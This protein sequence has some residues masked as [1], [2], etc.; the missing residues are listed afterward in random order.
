MK[1]LIAYDGSIWSDAA[2]ED[3][4][5][6]GLPARGEVLVVSVGDRIASGSWTSDLT[7]H[8]RLADQASE[9]IQAEFPNW[10]IVS[11]ALWGSPAKIVLDT[12]RW[13]HPDLLVVG[14]HGRSRAG[15]FLLGSVSTELIHKASCS[16]RVA[17]HPARLPSARAPR[18]IIGNDGSPEAE[19]VIRAVRSRSWPEKTEARIV[20]VVET[21]VP[22]VA[23]MEANTFAHE[24]AFEVIREVDE[25]QRNRLRESAERAASLLRA[26]GLTVS[27][28]V[29]DGA[30]RELL[31]SEAQ[32]LKAD[33]IFVGARGLGRMHRLL[34]G[35]VSSYIVTHARCSVEVVRQSVERERNAN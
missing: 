12:S 30:P 26:S 14:S 25:R 15:R 11:E 17:R 5:M 27:P 24:P 35:S 18:I 4:Q 8:E 28:S 21:L 34:L 29:L 23:A 22:S 3:L 20:S 7:E 19:A 9:R 10:S 33:A 32:A 16:V 1:I 13:F 31:L 2:I 6:A